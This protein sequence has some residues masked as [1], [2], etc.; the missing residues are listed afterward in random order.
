MTSTP[1]IHIDEFNHYTT[2]NEQENDFQIVER[3]HPHFGKWVEKFIDIGHIKVYE[4]QADLK[5][6]VNVQCDDNRLEKY[7]HHCMSVEGELSVNFISHRILASLSSRSFHNLFLPGDVYFLAMGTKFVN[8][9]VEVEKEYY[10]GLLCDS[11]SWSAD[12][13]RQILD[14]SIFY[15]GEFKLSIPMMQTIHTIFNSAMSGALKKV[16]I[17]AKVLELVA[18]QLH[19][20]LVRRNQNVR[21][22][23]SAHELF[24]EIQRYLDETFLMD[25]SLKSI[26]RHFGINEYVL[27]RGFKEVVGATVFDYL[28]SKRMGYSVQMLESTDQSIAEIGATVGYK[29]PNHFSAAFKKKFGINPTEYRK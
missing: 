9:H 2:R 20:S 12:L 28:L 1:T 11:E 29:Y 18:M 6:K 14:N 24:L 8:V 5:D 21:K 4:H 16:L 26:S 15:P 25:H 3:I 22:Q 13:K 7:V 17:E 23:E 19:T 27:K 10:L